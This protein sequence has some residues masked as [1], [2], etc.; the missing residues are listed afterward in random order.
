MAALSVNPIQLGVVFLSQLPHLTG[1]VPPSRLSNSNAEQLEVLSYFPFSST[2]T[3][4]PQVQDCAVGC[5]HFI[6]FSP[7]YCCVVPLASGHSENIWKLAATAWGLSSD[8]L[9]VS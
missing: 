1:W 5:S 3:S 2:M 6:L 8:F 7:G 4:E 9:D